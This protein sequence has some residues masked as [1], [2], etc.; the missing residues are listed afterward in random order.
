[1]D[2]ATKTMITGFHDRL[3][4]SGTAAG[5]ST[6]PEKRQKTI[7][8]AK[9]DSWAADDDMQYICCGNPL[10]MSKYHAVVCSAYIMHL[11]CITF[12]FNEMYL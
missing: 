8:E 3:L 1:M 11:C 5:E 9:D 4:V 12:M 10:H 2:G 6:D 7:E